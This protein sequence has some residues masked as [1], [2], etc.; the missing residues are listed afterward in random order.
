MDKHYQDIHK[1]SIPVDCKICGTLLPDSWCL[2]KHIEWHNSAD[3]RTE[4]NNFTE[5]CYGCGGFYARGQDFQNHRA[6]CIEKPFCETGD[7]ARRGDTA[8]H[9]PAALTLERHWSSSSSFLKQL[10]AT[11]LRTGGPYSKNKNNAVT[12]RSHHLY[13]SRLGQGIGEMSQEPPEDSQDIR[14]INSESDCW[15]KFKEEVRFNGGRSPTLE[16]TPQYFM[17]Q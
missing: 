10:I 3:R 12:H 17:E 14:I 13:P 15:K 16:H 6:D 9:N 7:Y 5:L 4:G 1:N 8:V 11:T 2:T